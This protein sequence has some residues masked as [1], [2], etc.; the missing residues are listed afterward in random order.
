MKLTPSSPLVICYARYST[1]EQSHGDSERR[2]I[3]MAKDWAE[4]KGLKLDEELTFWDKGV[5]A[6]KGRN[7]KEGELSRLLELAESEKIPKGSWLLV[8]NMDRLS[9]QSTF[10]S[11]DLLFR[12]MQ[13]GLKIVTLNDGRVI[14]WEQRG[15]DAMMGLMIAA[16]GFGT[17]NMESEKKSERLK[18]SWE[19]RRKKAAER[20]VT[21]VSPAW[22]RHVDGRFEA[23]PERAAIVRRVFEEY[24]L[25]KGA[26][27]IAADLARDGVRPWGPGR[28]KNIKERRWQKSYVTKILT[29]RTVIGEFQP[30]VY[31]T[32]N[33]KRTRSPIGE[34]V[35]NYYPAVISTSLWRDAVNRT[36]NTIPENLVASGPRGEAPANLFTGMLRCELRRCSVFVSRK[37]KGG[38]LR[39]YSE[40]SGGLQGWNYEN[41]EAKILGAI[42]TTE[43]ASLWPE[44]KARKQADQ[45]REKLADADAKFEACSLAVGRLLASLEALPPEA[46]GEVRMKLVERASEKSALAAE[47]EDL[48]READSLG[49]AERDAMD[50]IDAVRKLYCGRRRPDVRNIL[51]K[52]VRTLV[53]HVRLFFVPKLR[54]R[55]IAI[56]K[57]AQNARKLLALARKRKII[58]DVDGYKFR[59]SDARL[60]KALRLADKI[61]GREPWAE[62]VFKGGAVASTKGLPPAMRLAE[63]P[64][65]FVAESDG[66]MMTGY[67]DLD[68]PSKRG[69]VLGRDPKA[70]LKA[71]GEAA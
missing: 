55:E 16:M 25:G 8:E 27:A 11:V 63:E 24:V 33:G 66:G 31:S 64:H 43:A 12:L 65:L 48:R 69:I 71:L 39:A 60:K 21:T 4:R 57:Q 68:C 10:K 35:P 41:M 54:P 30:H 26:Y 6:F 50:G 17:G 45:A 47:V 37:S 15:P 5:S 67:L 70:I 53:S 62:I 3:S 7:A 18:A 14:H 49:E 52:H 38:E 28:S 29:S 61:N 51:S 32:V 1:P 56:L 58:D 13:S 42:L 40:A 20:P 44:G 46:A 19:G 36:K 23:I 34:P 9:R 2:Q 59:F 22:I